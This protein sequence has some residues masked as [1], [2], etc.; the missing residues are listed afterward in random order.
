MLKNILEKLNISREEPIVVAV[1]GGPDS[2][3]LLSLLEPFFKTIVCAHVNHNTGRIG[4]DLDEQLVEE[5]CKK[6]HHI[7]ETMKIDCYDKANFHDQAHKKRYY[8]FKIIL[9]KY[10]SHYLFTAHHGD[11]LVETMLFRMMR[12]GTINAIHGFSE[13]TDMDGYK[14]IRPLLQFT[15]TQLLEYVV[16]NDIPYRIDDSNEKDIY[17]RNRIRK[18]ILPMIKMEQPQAHL[19]FLALSEELEQ[20]EAYILKMVTEEWQNRFFKDTLLIESWEDL[21]VIIQKRILQF[22]LAVFYKEHQEVLSNKHITLLQDMIENAP[23]GTKLMFPKQLQ[24]RKE[25][26]TLFFAQE[27]MEDYKFILENEMMLPNG[28]VIKVVEEEQIDSNFVC[29]LNKEDITLPLI[30]RTR[31]KKDQMRVKGLNGSKKIKE[32]FINSKVPIHERESWPIV[33]DQNNQ[34][35]WIPGLKKSQFDKTKQEKYDIILRYY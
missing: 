14:M 1:S 5:Y 29:R 25:Y 3:A 28:H 32:I 33:T 18:N 27:K 2:M 35:V 20:M 10:K 7:F 13:V 17:T 6:H 31:Q 16:Q 24:I 19:K 11:D 15:K 12:G 22:T 8:F 26:Q 23:S 9:K 4:Q 21:D 34:I 30:I